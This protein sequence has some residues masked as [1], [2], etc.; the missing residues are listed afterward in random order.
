[1]GPQGPTVSMIS[2]VPLV[3]P[4]GHAI[5]ENHPV[6]TEVRRTGRLT[7][8]QPTRCVHPDDELSPQV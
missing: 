7:L 5:E 3:D 2:L 1:M 4:E 8:T 6:W